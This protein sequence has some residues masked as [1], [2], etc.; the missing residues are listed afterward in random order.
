MWVYFVYVDVFGAGVGRNGALAAMGDQPVRAPYSQIRNGR[1]I[2]AM[3]RAA[4]RRRR[5]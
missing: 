5:M 4:S 2:P 1:A 3:M